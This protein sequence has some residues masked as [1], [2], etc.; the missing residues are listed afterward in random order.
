MVGRLLDIT[1]PSA[2]TRAFVLNLRGEVHTF[3]QTQTV[4]LYHI[5]MTTPHLRSP[6]RATPS[7]APGD[8]SDV[9]ISVQSAGGLPMCLF[10]G[11]FV[12]HA[13]SG[14]SSLP[15][16]TYSPAETA[17]SVQAEGIATVSPVY[18]AFEYK[19]HACMRQP[20]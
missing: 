3:E 10:S 11:D 5:V 17:P 20:Q 14:A 18:V 9:P 12:P 13:S 19:L 16:P 1:G 15:S 2:W 6:L 8:P 7:M 4:A